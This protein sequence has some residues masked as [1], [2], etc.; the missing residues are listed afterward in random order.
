MVVLEVRRCDLHVCL[1][2]CSDQW[3]HFFSAFAY[4]IMADCTGPDIPRLARC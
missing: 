3:E 1:V 4:H 2:M